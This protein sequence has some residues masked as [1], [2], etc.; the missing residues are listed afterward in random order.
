MR[1]GQYYMQSLRCLATEPVAS[2]YR[3]YTSAFGHYQF[4]A[5]F[6]FF[7][8]KYLSVIKADP[9]NIFGSAFHHNQGTT[10][11]LAVQ[12]TLYPH[13]RSSQNGARL[14]QGVRSKE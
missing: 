7:V 13:S 10:D 9:G 8:R 11:L 1:S 4:F 5:P 14:I 12:R 3:H 2:S 6:S